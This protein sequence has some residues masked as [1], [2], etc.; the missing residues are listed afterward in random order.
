MEWHWDLEQSKVS[1]YV[2]AKGLLRR[3]SMILY[4]VTTENNLNSQNMFKEMGWLTYF[5]IQ[6]LTKH[7]LA[8]LI[9]SL[10]FRRL[11]SHFTHLL[12]QLT[13]LSFTSLSLS[14][15]SFS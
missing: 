15:F 10:V 1:L 14:F 4:V 13:S 3:Q 11:S 8:P 5:Q 12:S 9:L 2:T 7:V 6:P